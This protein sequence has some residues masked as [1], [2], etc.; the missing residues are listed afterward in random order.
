MAAFTAVVAGDFESASNFR[1]A[2]AT[3]PTLELIHE[4]TRLGA[5]AETL[6]DLWKNNL[7]ALLEVLP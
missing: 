3:T 1:A 5:D 4:R 6:S 7:K 2:Q